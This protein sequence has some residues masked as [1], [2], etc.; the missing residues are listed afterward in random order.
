[1][2]TKQENVGNCPEH[3]QVQSLMSLRNYQEGSAE[4]FYCFVCLFKPLAQQQQRKIP[5]SK[6]QTKELDEDAHNSSKTICS[7]KN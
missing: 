7:L 1:M 2:H 3:F 6:L 5:Y 4:S